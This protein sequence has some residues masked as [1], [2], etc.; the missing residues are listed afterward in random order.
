MSAFVGIGA[1]ANIDCEITGLGLAG[2]SIIT[3]AAIHAGYPG[4]Q[5]GHGAHRR[6]LGGRSQPRRPHPGS[7]DGCA[8]AA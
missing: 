6:Q 1:A 8:R 4:D 7:R 3:V 2:D 5:A